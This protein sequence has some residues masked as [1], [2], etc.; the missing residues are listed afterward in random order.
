MN[1]L[2][3]KTTKINYTNTCLA[4]PAI[5]DTVTIIGFWLVVV[6]GSFVLKSRGTVMRK[7]YI[8]YT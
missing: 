2:K 8:N 5:P 1:Q 3:Y 6:I 7:K 4:I